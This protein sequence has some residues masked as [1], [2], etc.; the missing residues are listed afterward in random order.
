[1]IFKNRVK[2][3]KEYYSNVI[4]NKYSNYIN[5]N[6]Q[7]ARPVMGDI[8]MNCEGKKMLVFG[9][10]YDSELWYNVTN[11][12]TFFIEDNKTYISLNQ[13]INSNNII[14]H[15]Y[16]NIT[17][18]KSFYLNDNKIENYTIP[19]QLLKHAPFDIILIDGPNGS[20]D[21]APGRLLPIFWS[22]RYLS[23]EG[24]IVYIDDSSR[25]LEKK[26]INKYLMNNPK[27]YFNERLGTMKILI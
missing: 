10:G 26:C 1:M 9:L 14:Y 27:T 11:K 18:K 6:I 5:K 16:K 21:D 24:T 7:L 13:N 20:N 15:E 4:L 8:I 19:E 3:S 25:N 12:N 22:K 17:V 2:N 23:K